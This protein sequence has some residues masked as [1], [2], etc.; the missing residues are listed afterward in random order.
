M[1]RPWGS[2]GSP[3]HLPAPRRV[4][5]CR[6]HPSSPV[7]RARPGAPGDQACVRTGL[8]DLVRHAWLQSTKNPSCFMAV[9]W[10][11]STLN[12]V[13]LPPCP[14]KPASYG[15]ICISCLHILVLI[16]KSHD[17]GVCSTRQH[18]LLKSEARTH[19]TSPQRGVGVGLCSAELRKAL[20][21]GWAS[22]SSPCSVSPIP[23]A[24]AVFPVRSLILGEAFRCLRLFEVGTSSTWAVG[25]DPKGKIKSSCQT[26]MGRCISVCPEHS[27]VW[28]A[29]DLQEESPW[30]GL[31]LEGTFPKLS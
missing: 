23:T 20:A 8:S 6:W 7:P 28:G 15:A 25:R 16:R 26:P 24:S 4:C 2:A 17:T 21:A 9:L 3:A 5:P 18:N 22:S 30:R 11:G 14:T 27:A 10:S 29:Q 13:P 31:E 1:P 12:P 19:L